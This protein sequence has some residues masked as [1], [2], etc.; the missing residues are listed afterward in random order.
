MMTLEKF[1]EACEVVDRVTTRTG[2]IYSQVFSDQCGNK[3]Y[4]KPE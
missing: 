4:L 1:E 2:L 3:V